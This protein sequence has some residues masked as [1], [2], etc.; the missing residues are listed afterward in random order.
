[1]V[2]F[3][4]GITRGHK[5]LEF[6]NMVH[7]NFQIIIYIDARFFKTRSAVSVVIDGIVGDD[8]IPESI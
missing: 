8:I 3:D 1:M 7:F 2:F 6:F 4:N 5:K